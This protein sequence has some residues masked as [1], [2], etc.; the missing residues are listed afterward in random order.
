[1][2]ELETPI[3]KPRSDL[4]IRTLSG[5]I[6]MLVAASAIWI[7]GPIF[8]IFIALIT[9]GLLYEW[10]KLALG[11]TPNPV[12]R[13]LWILGGL[14]YVGF[15]TAFIV[16]L[17]EFAEIYIL[18][19]IIGLVIST[20]T[21][22]YFAGRTFGGPKI[23]PAISPSKTWSG[24]LGGMTASALFISILG[25]CTEG[26]ALWQPVTGAGLAIVAQ[27][28]DFFESWMK[29]RAGV[30]DSGNLIPGHGGLF[31]RADGLVA[32]LCVTALLVVT[33]QMTGQP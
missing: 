17:R 5:V 20:D 33:L 25:Y 15:A 24:L 13:M 9:V 10:S 29:R 23:A 8:A 32:V 19:G 1:M 2:T 18:L 12:A 21:G 16:F 27:A 7:G 22:A 30:K 31:D 26:F 14:A 11:L 28:G 4:G 6:M 3:S